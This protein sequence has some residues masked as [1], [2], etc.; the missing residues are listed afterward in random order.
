MVGATLACALAGA[1]LRVAV[2]EARKPRPFDAASDYDQ[3]VSALSPGS[4]QILRSI[5]VWPLIEKRRLCPYQHMHVWDASGRGEIHFDAVELSEPYLGH[6]IENQVIQGALVERLRGLEGISWYCPDTVRDIEIGADGVEVELD[7]GTR[8]RSRLVVGA[9]GAASRVR[10]LCGI[11]FQARNYT[12][13]AVVANVS[14]EQSHQNT[15]WQRFLPTG[16]LAFLPLANGQCSIV[17]STSKAQAEDLVKQ[18]DEEFCE[19]L[20]Q[21]SEGK[22]GHITGTSSRAVFPL[23]GGQANPYILPRVALIGDAAHSIHPLA[24]QGV[25]LGFKDAATLAEVLQEA[26]HD[27]GSL[28]ILRRY[29]R[30]RKG[31]NLLTMRLMEGFKTL[32]SISMGPVAILRN[33]GLTIANRSGP[34]KHHLMRRAMGLSGER[35]KLALRG[36]R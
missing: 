13:N 6:I 28:R 10:S 18:E 5:G 17:W 4:E 30:A 19:M 11:T 23:R 3:R 31:D 35:P 15:A 20:S 29:E 1:G 7:S 25:N 27:I 9:D 21:A 14:T 2:V 12:Q 26:Q 22:L 32:F 33:A 16:P 34:L 8:I 24:G 36:Y